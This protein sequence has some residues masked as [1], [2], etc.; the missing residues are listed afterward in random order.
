MQNDR[1][2]FINFML[3]ACRKLPM[4]AEV[5]RRY[6]FYNRS[7]PFSVFPRKRIL[8]CCWCRIIFSKWNIFI[9]MHLLSFEFSFCQQDRSSKVYKLK[10][11]LNGRTLYKSFLLANHVTCVELMISL[12]LANVAPTRDNSSKNSNLRCLLNM[13]WDIFLHSLIN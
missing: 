10:V 4:D 11:L 7:W 3:H 2:C 13:A 8:L 9:K 5:K 1:K 12:F 6:I